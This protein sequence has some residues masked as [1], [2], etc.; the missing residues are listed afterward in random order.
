[1]TIYHDLVRFLGEDTAETVLQLDER[2]PGYSQL[3]ATLCEVFA[4]AEANEI[5]TQRASQIMGDQVGDVI[6]VSEALDRM[7]ALR[8]QLRVPA[9]VE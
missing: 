5:S 8:D 2:S 6:T 7:T 9:K 4:I 3:I 1:M